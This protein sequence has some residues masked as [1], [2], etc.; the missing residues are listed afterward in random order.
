MRHLR[1]PCDLTLCREV[2]LLADCWPRGLFPTA[3]NTCPDC[4]TVYETCRRLFH[5]D[6]DAGHP[7]E[8][9]AGLRFAATEAE[10]RSE[11][12]GVPSAAAQE[13]SELA[14]RLRA[15]ANQGTV[16]E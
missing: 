3:E 8:F 12:P 6:T 4:W 16:R 15:R 14:E 2:A 11:A 7:D 1:G 5:G 10:T 13:L 9:R